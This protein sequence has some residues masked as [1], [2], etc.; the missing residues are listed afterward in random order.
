VS[1]ENLSRVGQYPSQ[2]YALNPIESLVTRFN[3]P[4][5]TKDERNLL[6]QGLAVTVDAAFDS[7]GP[8]VPLSEPKACE[9]AA[10]FDEKIL[11]QLESGAASKEIPRD[12]NQHVHAYISKHRKR[13]LGLASGK[14]E[15]LVDPVDV[16]N[17]Y[18]IPDLFSDL[19]RVTNDT[20][21][22]WGHQAEHP[23]LPEQLQQKV[24]LETTKKLA[25]TAWSLLFCQQGSVPAE[26][27]MS[28]EDRDFLL[29]WSARNERLDF[30]TPDFF[31]IA[32]QLSF[33]IPHNIAHLLHMS[34]LEPTILSYVDTMPER[35]YFEAVAVLS[36]HITAHAK[37]SSPEFVAE[38]ARIVGM[39]PEKTGEWLEADRAYEF[40]LRC[41][42]FIGDVLIANGTSFA[43]ATE[44]VS[45]RML[46]PLVD[47][48]KEVSKY[49]PWVGLGALYIKGYK[50]LLNDG[51]CTIDQA[52]SPL[53]E[54]VKN[55]REYT[56][57][58]TKN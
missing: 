44:E 15:L 1:L 43:E 52:I 19:D 39:S 54:T 10:T 9:L 28:G 42:R 27:K 29:F 23:E 26:F 7:S 4:D 8:A 17:W 55:W 35:S 11:W 3:A 6:E 58:T 47:A 32:T 22:E 36:E 38:I 5:L 34:R 13:A 45:K 20:L 30:V 16:S 57:V 53:G 48:Q 49:L 56:K 33:D 21:A 18:G 37:D 24:S 46:V 25:Q 41:A 31:D 51:I 12:L 40:K 2:T 14:P 50:R